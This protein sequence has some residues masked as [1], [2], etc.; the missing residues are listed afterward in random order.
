MMNSQRRHFLRHV[1]SAAMLSFIPRSAWAQIYPARP[2]TMIIPFPAGG[3][4]DPVGRIFAE[5]MRVL[6]GQPVIVENVSGAN[7][8]IGTARLAKAPGDGY[9]IGMGLWNTHVANALLYKLPYDVVANFA[10]IALLAS[11]PLILVGKKTIPAD[12]L[13]E[14]IA[15]LKANPGKVSQ[16]SA[17]A[18]GLGHVTGA[19]FQKMTGTSFQHVPYRGSA[20]ALQ[21]V[22]AQ[23]VD[24]MID[25]A[26][27]FMPHIRAGNIKA[28]AVTRSTRLGALPDIPTVDEAGLPGLYATNWLALFAPSG[29]PRSII[30]RLNAAVTDVLAEQSVRQKIVDLGFDIPTH[31]EQS[32]EA[33]AE[34]QKTEIAKWTPIIQGAGIKIE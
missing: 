3:V 19:Y 9:T 32:P 30:A 23:Q 6:L 26:A 11:Y 5:R 12:S 21:D 33:L 27:V 10:P 34:F 17:G 15:W 18:G 13:S 14:L 24:L 2:I 28:Y 22:V 25:G 8:N 4:A 7:G 31:D 29:V 20:P 16:G 1:T